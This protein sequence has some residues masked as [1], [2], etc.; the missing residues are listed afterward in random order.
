MQERG[1]RKFQK[2]EITWVGPQLNQS[3]GVLQELREVKCDAGGNSESKTK[4]TMAS[5]GQS[6]G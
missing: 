3:T 5:H 2:E 4:G 6:G 1:W